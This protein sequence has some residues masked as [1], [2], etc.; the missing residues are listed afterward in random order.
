MKPKIAITMGDPAGVGPELIGKLLHAHAHWREQVCVVGMRSWADRLVKETGVACEVTSGVEIC[1]PGQPSIP[2]ALAAL[3]AMSRAAKGCLEGRYRAVVTGPIS[4]HWC[5]QAGMRQPGQTEFFADQWGGTPTMAFVAPSMRV[6]LATWHIPLMQVRDAL[7][8]RCLVR[9]MDHTVALVRKLG[10]QRPRIGVCGL[11]PHA[12]EEGQIGTEEKEII[13]PIL[14]RWRTQ[15][16][17]VELSGCHPADTLFYRHVSGE[18]DAVIALYHDQA[19]GPVKTV[20]FH[21]AVNVTLGLPHVRTSP[22]HG[23]AFGIAGKGQAKPDSL[24][25]A[26]ELADKLSG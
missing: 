22:D 12:G 10:F 25:R 16:P 26:L 23:T 3:D 11:N 1:E 18:F 13:H 5:Q 20:A 4:K 21:D 7:T 24:L 17:E 9:C 14:Q 19:L 6:S 8:E 15:H 2:G